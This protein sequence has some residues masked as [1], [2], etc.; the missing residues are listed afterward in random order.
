M[1]MV[2]RGLEVAEYL[3]AWDLLVSGYMV[4]DAIQRACLEG[5][6]CGDDGGLAGGQ[7]GA[8]VYMAAGLVRFLVSPVADEVVGKL[9]AVD[10]ARRLHATARICSRRIR[11]TVAGDCESK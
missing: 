5:P 7:I 10:I 4:Q 8:E 6:V 3:C 2:I 11:R 1:A 9:R